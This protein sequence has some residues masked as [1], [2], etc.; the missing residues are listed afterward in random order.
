ML[1]EKGDRERGL[2]LLRKASNR[3]PNAADIRLNLARG[4]NC[5]R[6]E[7]AAA[8]E[9]DEPREAPATDSRRPKSPS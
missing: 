8:K 3:A 2:E 6:P 1:V 5:G 4:L 7:E 9:L